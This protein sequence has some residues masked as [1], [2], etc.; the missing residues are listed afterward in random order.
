MKNILSITIV[1]LL[2]A[3]SAKKKIDRNVRLSISL[4]QSYKYDFYNAIYTVYGIGK[5]NSNGNLYKVTDSSVDIKF[6]L[7]QE[8]KNK[9][10][11]KYY[12]LDLEI[13]PDTLLL[14][15]CLKAMPLSLYTVKATTKR[16]TQTLITD[17]EP[18]C[19]SVLYTQRLRE[20]IQY[21]LDIA[22]ERPEIK[23]APH[24]QILYE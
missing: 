22:K 1:L 18:A 2:W 24:S 14:D 19:R 12:S 16:K 11:D 17:M 20:F 21:C 10:I 9:I 8:E 4:D 15:S 5:Y 3:C 6:S 23:K 13:L 7:S